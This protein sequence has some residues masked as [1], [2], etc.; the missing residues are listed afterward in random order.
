MPD[1]DR[2]EDL[3]KYYEFIMGPLPG[4]DQ[5]K[6][7]LAETVTADELDVFCMLPLIGHIPHSKLERK[8]KMPQTADA[9]YA[10]IGREAIIGMAVNKV[11]GP[12][13]RSR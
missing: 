5:F 1:R 6:R 10:K 3:L 9:L 8:A 7:T 4:R 11:S 13:R 2:Y 12:F